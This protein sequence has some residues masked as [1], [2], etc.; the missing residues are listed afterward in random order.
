MTEKIAVI[1]EYSHLNTMS[2]E[3]WVLVGVFAV[4]I[5]YTI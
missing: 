5:L 4:F 3:Q 1:F 2:V